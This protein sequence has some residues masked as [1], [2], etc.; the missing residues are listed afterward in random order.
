[1]SGVARRGR[2]ARGGA[3]AAFEVSHFRHGIDIR[4]YRF[5]GHAWEVTAH[6]V[7]PPLP[8]SYV[9]FLPV[10]AG[11]YPGA[12]DEPEARR[13]IERVL[14]EG[15]GLFLDLTEAGE[16]EPYA[17]LLPPHAR[18]VRLPV[19]VGTVPSDAQMEEIVTA[20]DR[21]SAAEG[22]F[23]YVHDANGLGRVGTAIGCWIGCAEGL[24]RDPLSLLD[25]L[26]RTIQR[27]WRSSPA[28]PQQRAFV[29]RWSHAWRTSAQLVGG[30]S[31]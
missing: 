7:R 29:R 27:P 28:L 14:D 31:R 8:G 11:P 25:E 9:V 5:V 12:A 1:M 24:S 18:H 3:P 6:L 13:R 10:L 19:R 16:C 15:C 21:F 26:R 17:Q 22:W 20:I 4:A 23:L 2:V 30:G